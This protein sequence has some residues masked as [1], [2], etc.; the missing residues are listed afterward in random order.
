MSIFFWR[1]S[2]TGFVFGM[3]EILRAPDFANFGFLR[4]RS[5]CIFNGLLI[6]RPLGNSVCSNIT[7]K[8]EEVYFLGITKK[9]MSAKG[10]GVKMQ[11]FFTMLP[12]LS[13]PHIAIRKYKPIIFIIYNGG[14][15]GG[16]DFAV[17]SLGLDNL[18]LQDLL[19]QDQHF[20]NRAIVFA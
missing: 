6:P 10:K 7:S 9:I 3:V 14:G 5:F 13:Q 16:A 20:P 2:L 8:W 1:L 17:I 18:L 12:S 11:Y 4:M 15:E 19:H